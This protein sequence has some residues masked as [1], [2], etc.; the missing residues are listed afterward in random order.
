V[1]L[2]EDA[3]LGVLVLR[4]WIESERRLRIRV[5]SGTGVESRVPVTSYAATKADAL[6]LVG[7]WIDQ[8]NP[9]EKP[10]TRR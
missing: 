5:S 9:P 2:E 10:V 1:I 7:E 3:P 6:Q 4:L 8:L